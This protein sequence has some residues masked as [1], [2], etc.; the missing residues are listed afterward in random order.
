MVKAL[1]VH[2]VTG[3][4]GLPVVYKPSREV[5]ELRRLFSIYESLNKHLVM[6]KNSIQAVLTENGNILSKECKRLLLSEE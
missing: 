3:E 6:L 4:F 2:V 5:R 1:W